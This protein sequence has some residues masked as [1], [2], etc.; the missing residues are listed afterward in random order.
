MVGKGRLLPL[1]IV[2]FAA[3][4]W[5]GS[6]ALAQGGEIT[7]HVVDGQGQSMKGVELTLLHAGDKSPRKQTSDTDGNFRFDRLASG[8]YSVSAALEGYSPVTCPGFR[9]ITGLSRGFAIQMMPEG[10]QS[11]CKF[12]EAGTGGS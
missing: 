3:L 12:Q 11:T 4:L 8:V 2:A 10:G 1:S 5:P 7:G 9:L 6:P